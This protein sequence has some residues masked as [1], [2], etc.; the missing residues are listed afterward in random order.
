[1]AAVLRSIRCSATS[2]RVTRRCRCRAPSRRVA[3]RLLSSSSPPRLGAG[4]DRQG[5]QGQR[6]DPPAGMMCVLHRRLLS[7][8]SCRP[9]RRSPARARVRGRPRRSP[10]A[11]APSWVR[12]AGRAPGSTNRLAMADVMR[13]P[14]RTRAIGWR[15]SWPAM[16]PKKIDGQERREDRHRRDDDGRD[17]L[18]R[19]AGHQIGAERHAVLGPQPSVPVEEGHALAHGE[20]E[21]GEQAG[22]GGQ[23]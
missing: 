2:V 20:P 6:G 15:I 5:G 12:S 8:L 14:T 3:P 9:R 21:H 19:P 13:P 18:L 16:D 1:M 17:P 23:A 4:R 11:P 10:R 22:D 7:G